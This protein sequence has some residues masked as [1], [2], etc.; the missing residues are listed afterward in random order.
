MK[1][2]VSV[3]MI[4]KEN[5][6]YFQPMTR[7]KTTAIWWQLLNSLLDT[8]GQKD[9]PLKRAIRYIWD[10]KMAAPPREAT[11]LLGHGDLLLPLRCSVAS[12]VFHVRSWRPVFDVCRAVKLCVCVNGCRISFGLF[13]SGFCFA[14]LVRSFGF[15]VFHCRSTSSGF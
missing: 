14:Y 1:T 15:F 7:Q 2:N 8:L 12:G 5:R 6:L 13:I 10:D 3:M 11:H 4:K 9:C